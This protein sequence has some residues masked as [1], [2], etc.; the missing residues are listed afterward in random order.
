[1]EFGSGCGRDNGCGGD[2]DGGSL[3]S[4][5]YYIPVHS[6]SWALLSLI[7]WYSR[8]MDSKDFQQF[9]QLQ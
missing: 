7:L 3:P 4:L 9:R 2:Q 6:F 5:K 1:M 8:V